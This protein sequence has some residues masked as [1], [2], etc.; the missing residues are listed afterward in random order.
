MLRAKPIL[1]GRFDSGAKNDPSA[2]QRATSPNIL[3]RSEWPFASWYL[4]RNS[5]FSF[6]MS[7]LDGHSALHPLHSRHSAITSC[8]RSPV[9]ASA[10]S[11]PDIAARS[12]FALPRVECSSSRV[13]MYDGHIVPPSTLRHAPCPLHISIAWAKL[14]STE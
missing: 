13:T 14:P 8:I 6:A 9:I 5:Y 4:P 1:S 3:S 10:G 11:A 7:T 2:L 12:A